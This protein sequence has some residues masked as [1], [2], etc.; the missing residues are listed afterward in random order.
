MLLPE[1][2]MATHRIENRSAASQPRQ[3]PKRYLLVLSAKSNPVRRAGTLERTFSIP[4]L[5]GVHG[6]LPNWPECGGF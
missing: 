2:S 1:R 5:G 4:Y 6:E 3:K